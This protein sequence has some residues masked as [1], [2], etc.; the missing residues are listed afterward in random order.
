M[1]LL[2]QDDE[3][4]GR[5]SAPSTP[6]AR[7]VLERPPSSSDNPQTTPPGGSSEPPGETNLSS[8]SCSKTSNTTTTTT[9]TTTSDDNS[10]NNDAG[11]AADVDSIEFACNLTFDTTDL[12]DTAARHEVIDVRI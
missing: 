1:Y 10:A 4:R 7:S 6:L 5:P 12:I 9:T 8:S 11:V 2:A 3:A